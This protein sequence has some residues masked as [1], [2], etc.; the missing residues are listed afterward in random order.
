[1]PAWLVPLSPSEEKICE[2]FVNTFIAVLFSQEDVG[3]AFNKATEATKIEFAEV[4]FS[5]FGDSCTMSIFLCSGTQR[6]LQG[7]KRKAQ[8]V[9]HVGLLLWGFHGSQRAQ[10]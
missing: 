5:K 4:Y 2:E 8:V 6:I 7:D 9:C 1:M 10:N 3:V